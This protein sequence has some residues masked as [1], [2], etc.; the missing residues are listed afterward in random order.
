[1]SLLGTLK[2]TI[3]SSDSNAPMTGQEL[4]DELKRLR[5]G[6]KSIHRLG[7]GMAS[8]VLSSARYSANAVQA[9]KD[10]YRPRGLIVND[11]P[12]QG[13]GHRVSIVPG[14]SMSG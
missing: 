6:G 12:V 8:V 13:G 1:M 14:E 3:R 5:R 2:S 9:A 10:Y 11:V 4:I 7:Q